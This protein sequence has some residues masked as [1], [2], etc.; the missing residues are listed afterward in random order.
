M[1]LFDCFAVVLFAAQPSLVPGTAAVPGELLANRS[2]E[3][4]ANADGTPDGWGL[5]G[6]DPPSEV[7]LDDTMS[8]SGSHSVRIAASGNGRAGASCG[9]DARVTDPAAVYLLSGWVKVEG[10]SAASARTSARITSVDAGGNV[11]KSDYR[12]C[13]PGPYDWRHYEWL[14]RLPAT[15]TRFNLVL[16]HHGDGQAWW[17][18]VSLLKAAPIAPRAPAQDALITDARPTLRWDGPGG[19]ATVAVSSDPAFAGERTFS[20]TAQGNELTLPEP[21]P[22]GHTYYWRAVVAG[23]QGE[24]TM[25]VADDD[26]P[27]RFFA[28]T[29]AE[30]TADWHARVD[31]V[32]PTLAQLRELAERN[33]MWDPFERVDR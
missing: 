29:W 14:V 24:L 18:D 8:H 13:D 33:V 6:F 7:Q 15:T 16:F 20:Y 31:Q 22:A 26:G 12:V 11:L 27:G 2:F 5:N 21:L 30:R 10:T 19:E 9:F 3:V 28:G 17:D 32:R 4:D 1:T 25:T 23:P